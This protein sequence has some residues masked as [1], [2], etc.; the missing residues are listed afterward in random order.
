[1]TCLLANTWEIVKSEYN[2]ALRK[3]LSAR[4]GGT[5]VCTNGIAFHVSLHFIEIKLPP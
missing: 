2:V 4:L 3:P 5:A 1:M